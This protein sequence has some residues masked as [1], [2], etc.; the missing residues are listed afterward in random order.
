MEEVWRDIQGYEGLYQVS[1]LGSVKSFPR[2][3]TKGG[4]VTQHFDKKGYKIVV[5]SKRSEIK[6]FKVHRLVATAFIPNPKKLPQV[7]HKD[8]NKVNNSVDNLEWCDNLYNARYGS[9]AKRAYETSVKAGTALNNSKAVIQYDLNGSFL[10]E[11]ASMTD[12]A[13]A[14]GKEQST[15]SKCCRGIRKSAYGFLWKYK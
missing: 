15:I 4:I 14:I 6:V 2:S 9:K 10:Q 12:A 3:R 5:L 11:Y 7:N 8:E 13:K 1:N